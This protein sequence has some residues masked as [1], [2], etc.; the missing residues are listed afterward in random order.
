MNTAEIF[1]FLCFALAGLG[2]LCILPARG[3]MVP[4]IT[5]L[6][7]LLS[8]L[9]AL[10]GGVAVLAGEPVLR[11]TLWHFPGLGTLQFSCDQFSALFLVTA[12]LVFMVVSLFSGEYLRYY[13]NRIQVNIFGIAFLALLVFTIAI[14]LAKDVFSFLLCW[15]AM[16]LLCYLLVITE[17]QQHKTRRAAYLM[18]AIGEAG[19]LAIAAA[20]LLL[21]CQA[22]SFS[23][24]AI[25]T[26]AGGLSPAMRWMVF[27]LSFF[28]FA[29]KTGLVPVNFWLPRAHP[30]APANMSAILSGLILNLGI[31]G[32]V[33][34][35]IDLLPVTSTGAGIIVMGIGAASALLGILYASIENDL[36]KILAHSS[37]ENMG[38]ICTGIGA[39]LIF[40]AAHHPVYASIALIAALYHMINH[41]FYKSLLFIGA[42]TVDIHAG[43]RNLDELGGLIKWMP[44][45]SFFFLAGTM[46]ISALPPFNGFVSEWLTLESLLR[47][48][49]LASLGVKLAFVLAGVAL[50]LTAG[51][52]V[53]CFVRTF[54]MGF[55]GMSRLKTAQGL[56]DG[57]KIAHVSM[58]ILAITCLLLGI[59]PTGVIP[60][61]NHAIAP[62]VG[63]PGGTAA[64]VPPLFEED[65]HPRELPKAFVA[66]FHNLGA[67][68]GHRY[69]PL[70]GLAII[71]RGG[72]ENPVVFAMSSSYMFIMLIVLFTVTLLV[73]RLRAKH[74]PAGKRGPTWAGGVRQFLP[75]MTYSAT[76][77]AQPVR[78]LFE[79]IFRPRIVDRRE[80]IA[81]HFRTAIHRERQEIHM[82]D[83]MV[84]YPLTSGMRRIAVILGYMHNGRINNYAA[85]ALFVLL[86]FLVLAAIV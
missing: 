64:L 20:F 32:I 65:G 57:G 36:K 52:A 82:I 60:V 35:N 79:A 46:A 29:T 44:W 5:A 11:I 70:R 40:R 18:L 61:I 8:G 2:M 81:T 10:A 58:A 26:A 7:G 47:S 16:G 3:R 14:P 13:V 59:L 76:G 86:L 50:T 67:Q 17:Y 80:S 21:A 34:V 69:I 24:P 19:T 75:E 66:D 1:F 72:K 33:R 45:T 37:I 68:V 9:A 25:K 38:I 78:V 56:H 42:G 39:A 27:M 71:H 31:Y 77:F 12:G 28:G 4:G 73:F 53:T 55:L 15:E 6:A 43:T 23:F 62:L 49:E 51:L 30:V 54:A 85:Y 41:S 74:Q 22:N 48:V 83:R 63:T 84:L